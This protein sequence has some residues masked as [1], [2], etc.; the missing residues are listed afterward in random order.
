VQ[1]VPD[2]SSSLDDPRER[3]ETLQ[4]DHRGMTKFAGPQDANYIKV[5][6]E[7]MRVLTLEPQNGPDGLLPQQNGGEQ[8][9]DAN[10][11]TTL[12][13]EEKGTMH[14]FEHWTYC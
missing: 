5:A 2:V 7:I 1:I 10:G 3:A 6:G 14:L 4:G 9:I 12:R 8:P 11:D 13:K